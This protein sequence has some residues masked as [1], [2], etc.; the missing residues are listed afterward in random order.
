VPEQ[1]GG[2]C[3]TGL[4]KSYFYKLLSLHGLTPKKG[5]GREP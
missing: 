2:A 4:A 1:G 3:G 5:R